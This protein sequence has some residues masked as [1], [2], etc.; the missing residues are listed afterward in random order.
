VSVFGFIRSVIRT[1][2]VDLLQVTLMTSRGATSCNVVASA[3]PVTALPSSTPTNSSV[4]VIQM[5]GL[6]KRAG[7]TT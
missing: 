4:R 2:T 6:A 5:P 3:T 1:V 7:T